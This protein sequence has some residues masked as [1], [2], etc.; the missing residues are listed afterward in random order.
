MQKTVLVVYGKVNLFLKINYMNW[1]AIEE[2]NWL[3]YW[4]GGNLVPSKNCNQS[5]LPCKER[6]KKKMKQN[7]KWVSKLFGSKKLNSN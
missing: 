1:N 6:T 3:F 5:A 4:Y 7:C 2:I